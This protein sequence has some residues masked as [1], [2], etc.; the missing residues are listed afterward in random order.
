[1]ATVKNATRIAQARLHQARKNAGINDLQATKLNN[2][3]NEAIRGIEE[4]IIMGAFARFGYEQGKDLA[5]KVL[6]SSRP[7]EESVEALGMAI[8]GVI[9]T[10]FRQA[11]YG[12]ERHDYIDITIALV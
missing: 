9:A 4:R 6:G 5:R 10:E 3:I 11:G 7:T 12:V 2:L 1:M 8:V